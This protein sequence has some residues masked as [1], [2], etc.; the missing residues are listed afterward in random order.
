MAYGIIQF[1]EGGARK[2]TLV[3]LEDG[4]PVGPSGLMDPL[5]LLIEQSSPA[6][7]REGSP[8]AER[9]AMVFFARELEAGRPPRILGADGAWGI[10]AAEIESLEGEGYFYE[11]EIPPQGDRSPPQVLASG[12][13]RGPH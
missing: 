13:A 12:V 5:S 8:G 2:A 11:V 1:L 3:R 10:T 4:H 7:V 6:M 9:M